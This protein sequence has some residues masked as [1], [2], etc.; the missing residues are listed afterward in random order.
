MLALRILAFAFGVLIVA[1]VLDAAIRNFMLPRGSRVRMTLYIALAFGWV[2]DRVAPRTGSFH[3]RDK[4]MALRPAI[5]LLLF[6]AVWLFLVFAGFSFILWGVG[7]DDV[8][9]AI[10]DSG[11][12]LFTLGFATP[13]GPAPLGVVFAEAVIG[14]T[15]LA[16]LISYLPTIYA[17]FQRREFMVAKLAIRAGSPSSPWAALEISHRTDSLR[18]MDE[19]IWN[20]WEN[21]F[22]ELGESHTSLPILTRYRSPDPENHWVSAARTVLDLAAMRIAVVDEIAPVSAHVTIRSGTIALRDIADYFRFPY[23]P[24]PAPSDPISLT[25]VQFDAACRYLRS[26]GLPL[27]ED[28]DQA[29][30]DFAGWRVNYDSIIE[31]AA[32]RFDAP[33][34]PWDTVSQAEPPFPVRPEDES[35]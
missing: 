3:R 20:E 5:T 7:A 6:Q 32:W 31:A 13:N 15:L 19:S 25:R 26:S 2:C 11:S 1:W 34:N 14:L 21:W 17:A 24:D 18:R 27:V 8:D 28:L 33:P 16:L 10:R 23:D 9:G 22:I 4:V 29:W 35:V 12:A 30:I